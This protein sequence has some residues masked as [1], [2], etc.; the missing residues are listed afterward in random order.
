MSKVPVYSS[1]QGARACKEA[2]PP[3]T[4]KYAYYSSCA[5]YSSAASRHP[6]RSCDDRGEDSAP[7]A[8]DEGVRL[9]LM[10]KICSDA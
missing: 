2:H 4:L 1:V 6:P 3:R 9:P 7:A 10:G 8:A 5:I